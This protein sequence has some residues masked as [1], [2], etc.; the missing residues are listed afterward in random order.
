VGL[1]FPEDFQHRLRAVLSWKTGRKIPEG[2]PVEILT[3]A[4]GSDNDSRGLET[5]ITLSAFCRSG[6]KGYVTY[7]YP[8]PGAWPRLL[9]NLGAVGP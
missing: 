9:A 4:E 8:E 6:R 1:N 3:R 5:W 2:T 7:G